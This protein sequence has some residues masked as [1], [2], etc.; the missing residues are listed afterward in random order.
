MVLRTHNRVQFAYQLDRNRLTGNGS[1]PLITQER[2]G[3][4]ALLS[5]AP[6]CVRVWVRCKWEREWEWELAVS[7]GS[8]G[9]L[10]HL[11]FQSLFLEELAGE[12]EEGRWY[13]IDIV[14]IFQAPNAVHEDLPTDRLS[15][16]G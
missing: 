11:S 2:A 3:S 9:I 4:R 12:V 8:L 7:F 6:S 5:S 14:G 10:T 15:G 1:I 16:T 13:T